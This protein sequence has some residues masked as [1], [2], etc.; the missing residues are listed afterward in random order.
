MPDELMESWLAYMKAREEERLLRHKLENRDEDED[1][2]APLPSPVDPSGPLPSL[3]EMAAV[4]DEEGVRMF[5]EDFDGY[6]I[7]A[8]HPG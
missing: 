5:E 3:G 2:D 7:V 4:P 1:G 8:R 6:V